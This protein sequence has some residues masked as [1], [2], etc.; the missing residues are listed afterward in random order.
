[1]QS[2]A[3]YSGI[4]L[5]E[6]GDWTKWSAVVS[7][8]LTHPLILG[9]HVGFLGLQRLASVDCDS[10]LRMVGSQIHRL[11]DERSSS[12]A[13]ASV[14]TKFSFFHVL[15]WMEQGQGTV[16]SHV[17]DSAAINFSLCGKKWTCLILT[18]MWRARTGWVML[19]GD[20]LTIPWL[21][22]LSCTFF[23]GS[24]QWGGVEN[25]VMGCF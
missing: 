13:V 8:S 14:G 4:T 9:P 16:S 5:L 2:C 22:M 12:H 20:I 15:V 10:V 11:P 23:L 21:S 25:H 24:V 17:D 18:E 1:M 19:W 7:S 6:E 3:K